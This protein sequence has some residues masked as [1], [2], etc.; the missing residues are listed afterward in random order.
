MIVE[1]GFPGEATADCGS[2][3]IS[4]SIFRTVG[5]DSYAIAFNKEVLLDICLPLT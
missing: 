5:L 4:A 1:G 2:S 3:L